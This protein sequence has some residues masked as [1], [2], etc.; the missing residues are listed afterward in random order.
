MDG[1]WIR[2]LSAC[3]CLI[4]GA[5]GCNKNAVQPTDAQPVMGVPM[6]ATNSKSLWGNTNP[7]PTPEA[8]VE[9]PRKGPAKPE[10]E[11]AIASLRLANA[12]AESTPDGD[13]AGLL[14]LARHGY[15]KA[16]QKDPK[17]KA[18]LL[19]LAQYYIKVNEREKAME[20]YQKYLAIYPNDRDVIYDVA[21]MFTKWQDWN[22]AVAWCDKALKTDPENLTYRKTKAFC[23]ACS[24]QWEDA[25]AV[26]LKI[27]PEAQARYNIARVLEDQNHPDAAR[28]QLQIALQ[29]DPNNSDARDLLA[30]MDQS[31]PSA[32]VDPNAIQRT[33]YVPDEQ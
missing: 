30:Q 22:N 1:R 33:G 25:F 13:R 15:Q 12:M 2:K 32:V 14:D 31:S 4:A 8:V 10:T 26:F 24:G 20:T 5:I 7:Q 27:M 11:V 29:V 16:L 6:T 17:N 28:Q 9:A 23:L 18:A 3:G 19:G 21:R